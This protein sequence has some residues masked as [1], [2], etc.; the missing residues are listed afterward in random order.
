VIVSFFGICVVVFPQHPQSF[1]HGVFSFLENKKL[2]NMSAE[3]PGGL[4][5]SA[6]EQR[7][8]MLRWFPP[9][10]VISVLLK[11]GKL[12]SRTSPL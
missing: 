10:C 3:C 5:I 7:K 9:A 11:L 4:L 12:K 1:F 6:P 8:H 2:L